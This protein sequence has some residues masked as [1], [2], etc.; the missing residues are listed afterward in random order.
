MRPMREIKE[1]SLMGQ[2][3]KPRPGNPPRHPEPDEPPPVEEPPR[4]IRPGT[5]KEGSM[6]AVR[7]AAINSRSAISDLL[8]GCDTSI[9]VLAFVGCPSICTGVSAV[10]G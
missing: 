7:V 4:P 2:R 5:G 10:A 3:D 8:R 6:P 1:F 9:E